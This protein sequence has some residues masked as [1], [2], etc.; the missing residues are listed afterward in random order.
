ME[1]DKG[2]Q[3]R[4]GSALYKTLFRVENDDIGRENTYL[5]DSKPE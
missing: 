1:G 4:E 5:W 3:L 2:Y